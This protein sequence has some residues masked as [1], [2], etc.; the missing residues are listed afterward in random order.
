[1][2]RPGEKLHEELMVR[3]GAQTTAHPKIIRVREDHL[4]ELEMAAALRALRDAID[5]G[6]D[7]DLLATLMRAV[8]EYQPQSQPE[9][10][11]PER[12]VN[13]LKAADK[14]AE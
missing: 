1:G 4:S 8:P 13:A 7:A 11:L 3:K 12:I 10:A 5:R 9:G 2:L 14:P 6:S